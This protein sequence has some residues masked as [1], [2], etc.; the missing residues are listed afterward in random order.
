MRPTAIEA[1]DFR[2]IGELLDS[3]GFAE[4][5]RGQQRVVLKPNLTDDLAHPVTTHPDLVMRTAAFI[6]DAA[7]GIE[8]VIADG[9]GTQDKDTGAI[10]E[11]L[12]Y[13][14]SPRALGARLVDLNS[15]PL[16][17]LADDTAAFFREIHLPAIVFDALLVSMPVLKAHS[18][19]G[20]TL[21]L[22]NMVGL[23]PPAFYALAGHWRKSYVHQDLHLGI[24]ELNRYR[25][26]DFCIL[27]AT[28]GMA[29]AHLWGPPCDPP[30]GVLACGSDPVAMDALGA[31]LL[32]RDW[33]RIGHIRLADGLLGSAADSQAV[34]EELGRRKP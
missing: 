20:V 19:A 2:S 30:V 27:D 13:R 31:G 33:R 16:R 11:R 9:C 29:Q 34:L 1:H 14:K 24:V 6:R 18:M 8:I 7:P 17:T 28:V 26:P 10:F 3:A 23:L 4:L 25:R 22:K 21:A 15:A 32:G 5:L 12:G